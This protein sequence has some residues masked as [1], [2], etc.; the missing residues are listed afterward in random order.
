M[1]ITKN[2]SYLIVA[3]GLF[4]GLCWPNISA[5]ASYSEV[6]TTS[7]TPVFRFW[8]P[9][10]PAP[11]PTPLCPTGQTLVDGQCMTAVDPGGPIIP[12]VCPP[13]QVLIPGGGSQCGIAT[14]PGGP[15]VCPPGQ[16][17]IPGSGRQCGIATDPGGPI[18]PT[19]CPT[20][21]ISQN[22]SCTGPVSTLWPTT[23][24]APTTL[25]AACGSASGQTLG[26][27]PMTNL[28]SAGTASAVTN[29]GAGSW[30]WTCTESGGTNTSCY[31]MQSSGNNGNMGPYR[32]KTRF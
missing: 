23:S 1:S 17:P 16:V 20:G 29:T 5:Q 25:T 18:I 14:D 4:S 21:Q 3:I 8:G 9:L 6:S 15:I 2:S 12:T 30:V 11:A 31:A 32:R 24:A 10:S 22:G 7:P 19:V 27:A 28:C 13:G 26:S